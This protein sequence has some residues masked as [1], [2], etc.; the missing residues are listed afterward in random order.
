[1][2][3][4]IYG[5]VGE[6]LGHSFS[7]AIHAALGNDAYRL[8]ELEEAELPAFLRRE[9]LGGLNVTIPYK[10]TVLPFVGERSPAVE[11]IGATNTLFYKGD[12][13]YAENTDV[14]GFIYMARSAGISV[15][16]RKVLVFGNG[17]AAQ[18]VKEA[19]R[20]MGASEL[21]V[22][23]VLPGDGVL[24]YEALPDHYDADVV[25]NTTPVGMFPNNLHSVTD[26]QPFPALSGVLDIVYNPLRTGLLLQA[27]ALGIPHAGGLAMLV[28]QAVRS[29]E[30]FFDTDVDDAV[31]EDILGTLRRDATNIALIG[32]PGSGKSTVARLLAEKT[33]RDVIELDAEIE[34]AAGKTIPEIFAE[35]G[36]ET[37][38]DIESACI[39]KAGARSGVIL[40][41]GGGAVT[42]E[43]NYLPLHQNSRIYCLARD[44][45]QLATDGRP[46]SKDIETLKAMEAERAPFYERFRDVSVRNDGTPEETAAAVL[47]DF[48]K[49][50]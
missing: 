14:L 19:L 47:D 35:D 26:L 1:M 18:A 6:H 5:L 20:R 29:H 41:L 2:E 50:A 23:D 39:A 30:F 4:K 37:F 45:S 38:R 10:Q 34:R 27:E 32:M 13:L 48:S 33:G 15:E 3:Q 12:V 28:A 49:N 31:I 43:R 25:V 16:G 42:K 40:S 44:L 11:A 8:Y 17:G 21:L 36:E 22:F 46:L 7:P 9:D 24:P